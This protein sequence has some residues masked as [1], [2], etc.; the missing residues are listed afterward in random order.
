MAGV[1]SAS[2]G[3]EETELL[4]ANIAAQISRLVMQLS[5]LEEFKEELADDDFYAETRADTLAQLEEFKA[6]MTKMSEGDMSLV[7][8]FNALQIAMEVSIKGVFK[9]SD[10]LRSEFWR[11]TGDCASARS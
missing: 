6:Q 7:D 5:D 2:R 9:N 1:S 10:V 3:R 8:E 11:P 4:K